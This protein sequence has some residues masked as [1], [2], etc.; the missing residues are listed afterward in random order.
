MIFNRDRCLIAAGIFGAT[1]II[2]G[3]FGAHGLE[4]R[5]SPEAMETHQTGVLYH[6]VHS[7]ALI[8]LAFASDTIWE[9]KWAGRIT[10]AWI[11]G[12]V[13]F[14]GSLYVLAITDIGI[15]GAITPIGGLAFIIGWVMVVPMGLRNR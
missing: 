1:S 11:L 9:S 2:V 4:A 14:S 12:I 3:A 8:A 6:L 7:L 13:V 5:L 15:L 10:V